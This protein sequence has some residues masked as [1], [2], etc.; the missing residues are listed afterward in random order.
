MK[1]TQR[2]NRC[3][4]LAI[5]NEDVLETPKDSRALLF[6]K[7]FTRIEEEKEGAS[8]A[9]ILISKEIYPSFRGLGIDFFDET[10]IKEIN[11]LGIYGYLWG[12]SVKVIEG[13]EHIIFIG[14]EIED[15]EFGVEE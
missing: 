4:S 2:I 15:F 8:V 9:Q 5:P 1:K 10:T 6:S 12:A 7:A 11:E 14:D 3:C 13:L